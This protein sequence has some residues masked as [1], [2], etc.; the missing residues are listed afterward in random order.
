MSGLPAPG[1]VWGGLRIDEELGRAGAGAVFA[2]WDPELGRRVTLEVVDA[3]TDPAAAD[4]FVREA[5]LAGALGHPRIVPVLRTGVHEGWACVITPMVDGNDL[6]GELAQSPLT[7][8]RAES[9]VTQIAGALDRAHRGGLV[10]G[11]LDPGAILFPSEGNDALLTGFGSPVPPSPHHTA[12]ELQDGTTRSPAGDVYSLGCVLFESLTGRVPFPTGS[13]E[14]VPRLHREAPRPAVTGLRPDLPDAVD[15]VVVEAMA[16]DPTRRYATARAMAD[17]LRMA[18]AGVH[19][20]APTDQDAAPEPVPVE[21]TEALPSVDETTV[22]AS[23]FDD[24]T[25]TPAASPVAPDGRRRVVDGSLYGVYEEDEPS[26][27][28]PHVIAAVLA[29]A[30]VVVGVLVWRAVNTEAELVLGPAAA[31]TTT[32][33]PPPGPPTVEALALLVPPGLRCAPP[34]EQPSDEPQRVVLECPSDQVPNMIRFE[35]YADADARDG[36]FDGV[37]AFLGIPDEGECAL[38]GPA[39]HDFIGVQR[40]GRVACRSSDGSVDFFW[41]SDEAPLLISAGGPGRYG[42]HYRSWAA[43]VDRTDAAFPLP[44]ERALLDQLPEDLLGTCGRDIDLLVEAGAE[45]AATCELEDVAPASVSWARFPDPPAMATWL[46]GRRAARTDAVFAESDAACTPDG[47][48]R[49][50]EP[51]P[52]P[53]T[54]PPPTGPGAEPVVPSTEPPPRPDAGF[55]PYR[56][57]ESTGRILCFVDAADRAVLVWS[58]DQSAIGSVATGA[59][60]T[61]MADLLRWWEDGGHRP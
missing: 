4:R 42:D 38:G 43:L 35:L 6:A 48:G 18:V 17:A 54:A 11:R 49:P 32:T 15:A 29:V 55:T 60:G 51:P 28:A 34:A 33:A 20:G 10:H 8:E 27:R 22:G 13:A 1:S 56:I 52:P 59:D 23:V 7:L 21:V 41:T 44:V 46:D 3:G 58:R 14:E 24:T 19:T 47:F 45:A 37:V 12:P 5:A 30:V 40:V 9:M 16:I 36:A 50:D 57:G 2:A 25:V 61:S 31:T 26:S 53:D 39:T